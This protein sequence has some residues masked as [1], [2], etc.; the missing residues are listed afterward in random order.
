MTQERRINGINWR[1]RVDVVKALREHTDRIGAKQYRW[2]E[3]ALIEKLQREG[4]KIDAYP[5]KTECL[6]SNGDEYIFIED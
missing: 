2:V 5:N 3:Q 1:V 6:V 4:V